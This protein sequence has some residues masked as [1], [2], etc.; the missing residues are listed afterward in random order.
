MTKN[1]LT[2]GQV[3]QVPI[4]VLIPDPDQPR[5]SFDEQGLAQLAESIRKR[6]ILVPLLVRAGEG[7][8][9][10]IHDGERRL[11]AARLAELETV[12]VLLINGES[13]EQDLRT[14]QLAVNNLREQLKP[15]EVA[16]LLADLQRKHFAS[17]NDIAAHLDR[18]GLP[19]MKPKEIQ[20]AIALVDLPQWAQD[21]ID[22]GQVEAAAAA[23]L[24]AVLQYP[25]VLKEAQDQIQDGVKWRGRVTA[26]D[27]TA[28]IR[29]GLRQNGADLNATNYWNSDPVHFNP[30]TACKGCE[31]LV[32]AGREKFCM[33]L[34]EFEKKNAEAKAA[35]LLP[36]GKKPDKPA[37]VEAAPSEGEQKAEQRARTLEGKCREYLH[38][39]LARR[40]IQQMQADAGIDITDELLTW[41]AM[42]RPGAGYNNIGPAIAP[43][44]ARIEGRVKGLETLFA[45][46]DLAPAKLHAAIEIAHSLPWR[47]TQVIC[48]QLWGVAL[49][50]VWSMD[51]AFVNLFR[52]AELLRLVELHG[53]ELEDGQA[54]DKLKV[55]DLKAEILKRAD[56]VRSPQI[57]E[58]VYQD[59]DEPFVRW[60][61]RN[62]DDEEPQL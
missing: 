19:A 13:T 5:K 16:R 52:K 22:A 23:Q 31:H 51:E 47:E 44:E 35:G 62:Y 12:P 18:N 45:T 10:V 30:K 1:M 15:M 43:Y 11:R 48:H 40:I 61:D 38:A 4:T 24:G 55:K 58:D 3:A 21:L 46:T 7:G 26:S 29:W 2:A 49:R 36:G 28:A 27:V 33:N 42:Q 6:G 32:N 9:Y 14:G 37:A 54:W 34:P 25:E 57:L 20:E 39:Y 59:V 53:L 60:A 41:H 17:V 8:N 50:N 56:Q